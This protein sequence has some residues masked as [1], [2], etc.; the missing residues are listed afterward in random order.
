MD[1]A[2]GAPV[3]V[4]R[5]TGGRDGGR[6]RDCRGYL[7]HQPDPAGPVVTF[8]LSRVRADGSILVDT[9]YGWFFDDA[10]GTV[11]KLVDPNTIRQIVV[12]HFQGDECG[13]RDYFLDASPHAEVLGSPIAAHGSVLDLAVPLPRTVHDRDLIDLGSEPSRMVGADPRGSIWSFARS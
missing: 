6:R 1:T 8:S 5:P 4:A 13:I 11:A 7:P 9:N 10:R 12:L 2:G 3:H